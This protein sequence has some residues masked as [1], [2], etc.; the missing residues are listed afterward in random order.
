[1]KQVHIATFGCQMNENDSE[2]ILRLL[3]TRD[4]QPTDKLDQADLILINTCSIRQKAEEKTYSLLGRLKGLKKKNP[5][6]IIGVGGCVA[7]QEGE[8]LL[9]RVPFLDLVFGTRWIPEL[10]DLIS[11]VGPGKA[12]LSRTEMITGNLSTLPLPL[13]SLD[14]RNPKASVTIMQGCNNYCAYC[15]VPFVRGP[16]ESRPGE[17][18]L[19]EV[20]GLAAQ[21]V[22][23]ILLLGQNVNSYGQDRRGEWSFAQLLVNLEKIPGLERIR[24][25]TSHPK[26]LSQDLIDCFG[27]ISALCEH[28]HLPV[29]AGSNRILKKM[30]RGYSRESYLNMIIR[31][32]AQCPPIALTSDVIVGFPGETGDDFEETMDLIR[33]V[34]FD[35][36]F[37]FKYSDR[38]MA[39]SRNF[40]EK[41]DEEEK[42]RRLRELQ[43]YQK[44]VTLSKNQALE[45][46]VQQVIVEGHSKKNPE[47]WMGR[48][49][50]N[51]I[52]N[53]PGPQGLFGKAEKVLIERA[54]VHSLKGKLIQ[55]MMG[56][57]KYSG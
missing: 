25:T 43:S 38:P 22:K 5:N 35:D 50:S 21:G 31:L 8:R 56:D 18:I 37:S 24:F 45:G 33:Q 54:Y 44:K 29:Q 3:S 41:V 48:T 39:P 40:P 7:Q 55:G 12:R 52:V 13:P 27:K 23:E 49:G 26:D 32:R 6:L 19:M 17:E 51:K 11:R 16:E 30:N 42:G 46:T 36:L 10:P 57:R 9:E 1:M 15:V 4:Y 28:F 14:G 34:Q 47:E 20:E 2:A 53:F